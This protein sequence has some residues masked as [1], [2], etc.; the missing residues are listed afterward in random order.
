M[1]F[2]TQRRKEI[3]KWVAIAA[4]STVGIGFFVHLFFAHKNTETSQQKQ[5]PNFVTI[6]GSQFGSDAAQSAMEQQQG[7][8]TTLQQNYNDLLKKYDTLQKQV[9]QNQENPQQQQALQQQLNTLQQQL[10]QASQQNTKRNGSADSFNPNALGGAAG[11]SSQMTGQAPAIQDFSVNFNIDQPASPS[12][13]SQ[14]YV[15][16]GTKILAVLTGA[17]DANAA[18]TGQ[19]NTTPVAFTMVSDAIEPTQAVNGIIKPIKTPLKGCSVIGSAYGDISSERAEIRLVRLSCNMA[20]GSVLDI[21][22]QGT[23]YEGLAGIKGTPIMRNGQILTWA[24]LSGFMSGIGAGLQQNTQTSSISPLGSTTTTNPGQVFQSG[25]YGGGSTALS[26]LSNYYIQRA[27][28]YH[29]VIE[30]KPG[31][32]VT[33]LFTEGFSIVPRIDNGNSSSGGSQNTGNALNTQVS[34]NS[35][36][37]AA[38]GNIQQAQALMQQISSGQ[39]QNLAF[40]QT[41]NGGSQ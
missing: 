18:V 14:N 26:M 10:A 6:T 30:I 1:N 17:A 41:I 16:S 32:I 33:I 3:L 24:G 27:E 36:S 22:V 5:A 8:I 23:V 38:N 19:S 11:A 34:T 9:T 4:V 28:Q 29:P 13:N 2:N 31:A 15:P 25:V 20:N 35:S 21:P 40:G 7:N 12:V 37:G 39:H